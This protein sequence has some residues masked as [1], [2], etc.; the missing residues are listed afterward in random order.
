MRAELAAVNYHL[1]HFKVQDGA[2]FVENPKGLSKFA[3][4][5]LLDKDDNVTSIKYMA[6]FLATSLQLKHNIILSSETFDCLAVPQIGRL[7]EMLTG[8]EVRIAF[9]HRDVLSEMTS[10]HFE[11]N[12]FEHERVLFSSA[13]SVHLLKIMEQR[14][15][16]LDILSNYSAVF[17]KD[18]LRIIDLHGATAAKKEVTRILLCQVAGVLCHRSNLTDVSTKVFSNPSYSLIPSQVFSHFK[19]YVWKQ[20][21][22]NC[23][24]CDS[25][26]GAY[27]SFVKHYENAT[28]TYSPPANISTT[29][30]LLLPY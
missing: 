21:D 7:K 9:V 13:F 24:F 4:A 19:A 20:N 11:R 14:P 30:P 15:R 12:R 18:S 16:A 2:N 22:G 25:L 26:F 29:L 5:L 28:L 27:K 3:T 10:F 17:G 8:F 6:K 1:P 23:R